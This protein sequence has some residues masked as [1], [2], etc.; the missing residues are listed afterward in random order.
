[1]V[2][3]ELSD[4]SQ[5]SV[6]DNYVEQH[7]KATVYHLS[8]WREIIERV[9]GRETYYFVAKSESKIVGILPVVRLR[10]IAFGDFLVSMPYVNYG[11][12]L[13][14][15][16]E[17]A[18]ELIS[19]CCDLANHLAV[20]HVELRHTS[21]YAT[22]QRRMDKVSMHL[23]LPGCSD[24]LWDQLGSKLR[25]QIKR[26]L[27][28]GV[29]CEIGGVELIGE[30]YSV[31]STKYRDLGIPVYPKS[32]FVSILRKFHDETRVVVVRL[33][34]KP[35]AAS[36]V[37]GFN[38]TVEVPLASSMRAADRIGVNMFLYWTMLKHAVDKGY[39]T[40]D[41]GRSS[42]NSGTYR[43]KKQW[44]AKPVQLYW[45]YWLRGQREIPQF[46]LSGSKYQIAAA[47]WRKL[48]LPVANFIGP[49]IVKNLP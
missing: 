11:G 1:V 38:G 18:G 19:R 29:T 32:W 46:N 4:V 22:M 3:V 27:R 23:T 31:F 34:G 14:D 25:A 7:A 6:W 8:G 26:P 45:H 21:D 16:S 40:F 42:E 48:P 10:S 44:G 20:D 37:I 12:V 24:E 39:Q 15:N 33:S 2:N 5:M 49:R 41:F 35:V 36:L 30:F 28:E 13:S 43:F 47:L 17:V 9:F